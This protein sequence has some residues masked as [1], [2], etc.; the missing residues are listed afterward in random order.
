MLIIDASQLK[1]GDEIL[2]S[3]GGTFRYYKLLDEPRMNPKTKRISRIKCSTKMDVV[4]T[5]GWR[6]DTFYDIKKFEPVPPEFHNYT[7]SVDFR[8]RNV[9]LLYRE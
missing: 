1:K 9:W 5:P 6:A 2:V 4:R 3:A 7:M 8:Y